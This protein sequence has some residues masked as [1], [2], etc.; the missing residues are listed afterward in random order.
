MNFFEQQ[1][2]AR[3]KT[4]LLVWL[5][6]LAVAGLIAG[7][8]V[9]VMALF[10]GGVEQMAEQQDVVAQLGPATFWRPDIFAGVA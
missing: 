1:E 9:L 4:G 3:R 6:V 7:T 2:R 10:L 5:F 8:Y